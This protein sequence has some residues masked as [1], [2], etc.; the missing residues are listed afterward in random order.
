ME[1]CHTGKGVNSNG[2]FSRLRFAISREFDIDVHR[3]LIK[4]QKVKAQPELYK[5]IPSTSTFDFLDLNERMFYPISFRVVRFILPNG[6]YK[7]IITNLSA[8]DFPPDEIKI[9]CWSDKF[10]RKET[11]IH[12]PR[13]SFAKM[14][15]YNF[16]KMITSH[17]G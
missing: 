17:G 14:I 16:A 12:H 13:D 4:K 10:S 1:L 6:T 3:T 8:T 2:I 11:R 9:P 5:Y 15:M 7:T